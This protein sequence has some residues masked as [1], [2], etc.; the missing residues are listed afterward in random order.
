MLRIPFVQHVGYS[1]TWRRDNDRPGPAATGSGP[2]AA[3]PRLDTPQRL[4]RIRSWLT[5]F[6]DLV[7][8]LCFGAPP[9]SPDEIEQLTESLASGIGINLYPPP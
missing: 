4:R 7:R 2:D 6:H 3:D 1:F 8:I 5:P 9:G